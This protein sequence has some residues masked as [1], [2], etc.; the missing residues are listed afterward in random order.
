MSDWKEKLI[1][2]AKAYI[3]ANDALRNNPLSWKSCIPPSCTPEGK[4]Y[5]ILAEAYKNASS[6]LW[7]ITDVEYTDKD[8]LRAAAWEWRYWKVMAR[9]CCWS[10]FTTGQTN[11]A[12]ETM[13]KLHEA[14]SKLMTECGL[15]NYKS[16]CYYIERQF[17]DLKNN[18]KESNQS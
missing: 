18:E 5:S 7:M 2:C 8:P 16:P 12:A 4:K 1:Q 9:K 11:W 15:D 13:R 6:A 10:Q 17:P 14:E 3:D